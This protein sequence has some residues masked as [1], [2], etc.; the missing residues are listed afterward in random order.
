GADDEQV[1]RVGRGRERHPRSMTES[2][3]AA[4][5]GGSAARVFQ[6]AHSERERLAPGQLRARERCRTVPAR[7][8][9]SGSQ[10]PANFFM[11]FSFLASSFCNASTASASFLSASLGFCSESASLSASLKALCFSRSFLSPS[12]PSS[13]ND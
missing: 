5:P 11:S 8:S 4:P 9:F 1:R 6:S 2:E 7:Y 3:R 13:R 12:A 10:M